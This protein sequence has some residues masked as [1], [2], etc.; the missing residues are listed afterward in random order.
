MVVIIDGSAGVRDIP[1][2]DQLLVEGP[3]AGVFVICRDDDA[4]DLPGACGARLETGPAIGGTGVY[5]ERQSGSAVAVSRL[6][7]VERALGRGGRPRA[8]PAR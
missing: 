7:Q 3:A 6:D 8:G 2:I 1:G 5:T 4:R